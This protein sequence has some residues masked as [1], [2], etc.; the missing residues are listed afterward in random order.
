MNIYFEYSLLYDLLTI[1]EEIFDCYDSLTEV[2]KGT[3]LFY[4]KIATLERLSK[5]ED[6]FFCKLPDL[7]LS[8]SRICQ[9]VRLSYL[10][11]S[12]NNV[13]S[14]YVLN[15]FDSLINS[16]FSIVFDDACDDFFLG[17]NPLFKESSVSLI[18]QQFMK[19]YFL[20]LLKNSNID[21]K[22][23]YNIV[24][25]MIFSDKCLSD[26][27]IECN[28]DIQNFNTFKY[29]DFI[30]YL[31][32]D[33][34]SYDDAYYEII[35]EDALDE[36]MD[37]IVNY[38]SYS[39]NFILKQKSSYLKYLLINL[40]FSDFNMIRDL[41]FEDI[42][43]LNLDSSGEL[44]SDIFK[45]ASRERITMLPTFDDD[46]YNFNNGIADSII[47]LI[48]LEDIIFDYTFGIKNN[49]S[50]LNNLI[51]EER[52]MV[53]DIFIVSSEVDFVKSMILSDLDFFIDCDEKKKFLITSRIRG[54]FPEIFD[55]SFSTVR[56]SFEMIMSNH[57][58]KTLEKYYEQCDNINQYNDL[59]KAVM[60]SCPFLDRDFLVSFTDSFSCSVLGFESE[61]NYSYDKNEQL[62]YLGINLLRELSFISDSLEKSSLNSLFQFKLLEFNDIIDS[63]NDEYLW[64]LYDDI[65][66]SSLKS[67]VHLMKI[68]SLKRKY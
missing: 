41:L 58:A 49:E 16:K 7:E 20:Y 17:V 29:N 32:V 5:E 57:I 63:V 40:K 30:E 13:K 1:Q 39:N 48:K 11:S 6:E 47:S 21:K 51:E 23:M 44:L 38:K 42:K 55:Y 25:M 3:D 66:S 19:R 27:F 52:R 8:L 68:F 2:D 26:E 22:T 14:M 24:H 18:R 60:F 62:Y 61:L 9:S 64:K 37:I 15:R 33:S 28:F 67:N 10:S 45:D 31:N 59:Y 50:I 53:S 46:I 43:F 4:K 34:D 36:I 35:N 65:Q 56:K 54:L 12:T